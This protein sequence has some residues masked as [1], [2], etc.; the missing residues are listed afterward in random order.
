MVIYVWNYTYKGY[1][2]TIRKNFNFNEEVA[3]HLEQIAKEEAKTQTQYLEELI[4]NDLRKKR[5]AKKL[6]ALEKLKGSMTGKIGDVDLKQIRL[7]RA[8]RRAK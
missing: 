2:M 7:E 3:K 4:E 6:E 8:I 1:V 5:I